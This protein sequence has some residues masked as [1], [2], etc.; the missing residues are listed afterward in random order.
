MSVMIVGGTR[1]GFTLR[2]CIRRLIVWQLCK[3][4]TKEE[5]L[6]FFKWNDQE[7]SVAD[8]IHGLN[9]T[10]IQHAYFVKTCI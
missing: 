5:L 10:C 7:S 1:S 4:R 6:D 8:A 9:F 2:V 3:L